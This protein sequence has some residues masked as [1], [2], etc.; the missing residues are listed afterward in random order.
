[1]AA[2]FSLSSNTKWLKTP[3]ARV[4]MLERPCDSSDALVTIRGFVNFEIET[5][6]VVIL[7]INENLDEYELEA[8]EKAQELLDQI[9]MDII[10]TGH[11][12]A[13]GEGRKK[14]TLVEYQI[15]DHSI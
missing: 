3:E 4:F 12:A 8:N 2:T 15:V 5:D 1:M 13:P 7:L 14:L 10:A 11:L 6:R 9:D